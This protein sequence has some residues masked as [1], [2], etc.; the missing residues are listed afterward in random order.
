MVHLLVVILLYLNVKKL[1]FINSKVAI[2]K[3]KAIFVKDIFKLLKT[4]IYKDI[5]SFMLNCSRGSFVI[6][7]LGSI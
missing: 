7:K 2:N 6:N 1:I 5:N 4:Y 3:Y